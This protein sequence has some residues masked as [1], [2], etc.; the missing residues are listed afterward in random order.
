MDQRA[1]YDDDFLAWSEHQASAL[2]ELAGS[3]RDLPN[4]LDLERVAEE[5]GDVGRAELNAVKSHLR[6]ILA[7]LIKAASE[8]APGPVS[9]WR[10]EVVAFQS[11][12]MD[13][14]SPSMAQRLDLDRLWAR[15]LIEAEAALDDQ[16]GALRSGLPRECPFS[17]DELLS[18]DFDFRKGV[19]RLGRLAP[20]PPG[21]GEA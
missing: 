1:T 15:A 9:H 11:A 10:K 17:L 16:A 19:E 6:Q 12:L 18:E 2:R 5:I 20:P 21:S 14:F 8:E 13:Q 4:D 7:H 3:R